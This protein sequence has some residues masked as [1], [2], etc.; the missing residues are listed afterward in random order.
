MNDGLPLKNIVEGAIIAADGPV[1]IDQLIHL[2]DLDQ[3]P[4]RADIRAVLTE[5]EADCE[6]RGFELRQVASGYR[7]QVRTEM[8]EW[9]GRLWDEKPP[10]YSR[11]LLETL[12]LIAYRQPV[13]RG[14]IEE[15]R[16]VSVSTNIMRSLL[17]REWVRVVGH[18]DVPGRPSIYATT[19]EFL[20]YFNL[21]S[22]EELPTLSAIK[23]LDAV[24]EQLDLPPELIE[25][26]SLEV[27]ADDV[28]AGREAGEDTDLDAVTVKVNEI[29]DNI[30]AM[31]REED[32]ADADDAGLQEGGD[33]T[34]SDASAEA[35]PAHE[36]AH[37][38]TDDGSNDE[39]A[40]GPLSE[41]EPVSAGDD[42]ASASVEPASQ[43]SDPPG[44]EPESPGA[45][46]PSGE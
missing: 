46:Q 18:R 13:T 24:N 35:G 22:L 23:D 16:G 38:D 31:F 44:G 40:V 15:V 20:D 28:S 32:E 10:R 21:S 3:Q 26:R 29:S 30:R 14:D 39:P 33:G 27:S 17:E 19:R 6:G 42:P 43:E 1:S 5:I 45:S 25:P 9:V 2:F 8:A 37:E 34:S 7:F 4:S 11:A 41:T 12:A 36:D